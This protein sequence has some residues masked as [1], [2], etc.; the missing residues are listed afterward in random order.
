[1]KTLHDYRRDEKSPAA[2]CVCGSPYRA[3]QH[4]HIAK[5]RALLDDGIIVCVC[6]LPRA[7][8]I[9]EGEEPRDGRP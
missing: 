3:R 8:R 7:H 9:H 4:P 5:G 1:V 6:G 2:A